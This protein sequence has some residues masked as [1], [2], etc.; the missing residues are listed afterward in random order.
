MSATVTVDQQQVDE[1]RA[2]LANIANGA[3]RAIRTAL[4]KTLDGAVTLTAKRIGQTVT[5]K[6]SLIK[7]NIKKDRATNYQLGA[8][9]RMT[10]PRIPLAAYS[11]NPT[12]ATMNTRSENGV[13]VKVF[14][15]R[16]P[17]RFRHA[18]F[19]QM[20]NGYIG[21]F[22]REIPLRRTSSG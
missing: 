22:E 20:S 15:D 21:L 1:V 18:F 6:A 10:S 12:A 2:L 3:E 8:A 9:L 19:A 16:P 5:L 4:N 17:V 11:T 13:S 14:K 7:D